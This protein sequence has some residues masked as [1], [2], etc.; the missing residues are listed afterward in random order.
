MSERRRLVVLQGL[1]PVD[2]AQVPAEVIAGITLAALA[3]PEVL[4]YS[5]IA[6]MPV[7]TGLYT[8]VLP[9]FVF[10][11]FGSS[12]H[13]VV[14]ADS[15]TAAVMAAALGGMAVAGSSRYVALAGL[16]ALMAGVYLLVARLIRLGF[17]AD[18]LSRTVL[19]GFLSGVG[20]Q[21]AIGQLAEALGIPKPT[22]STTRVLVETLRHVR[23][24]SGATVIVSMSV[25]IVALGSK[26]ISTR[27]PGA[28]VAV[29]GSIV[30]S[31]FAHLSQH[32]VAVLGRVPGGLPSFAV[33]H[34]VSWSDV[35]SLAPTA[36]SIL[37]LVLAQS[38]ATS[39]AYAAKY[40]DDFDENHDLTGLGIA[41]L[42]AAVTGTFV[43]NGSP[44]KTQMLDG[45]GGRSQL[46]HLT[47]ATATVSVLVLCTGPLQYLPKPALATIVLMIGL[48]L[49]DIAG[50]RRIARV[51][52]DEFVVAVVTA[53]TVVVVGVQQGIEL[54]IVV[55]IID[56]L[57]RSYRPITSVLVERDGALRPVAPSPG[58]RTRNALVVFRFNASLYY[59]NA[60]RFLEDLTAIVIDGTAGV[61]QLRWLCIDAGAIADVD[62]SAAETLRQL[63]AVAAAHGVGIAWLDL[64][65][66]VTAE[67]TT[68]GLDALFDRAM[69]FEHTAQVLDA[70]GQA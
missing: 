9:A 66:N 60:N 4:G 10:A 54:A 70:C 24:A 31:Y 25:V 36:L 39:R 69:R 37:V 26:L 38:A 30:V 51:R 14:G 35:R 19:V 18:F 16:L 64:Q 68:F 11:I 13:L 62:Y 46:A 3:I 28:L 57:R 44:T 52:R 61:P 41:N 40:A 59:A 56:H 49:V 2:R 7:V 55:A 20:I 27:V 21:V 1:R 8:L 29:V 32:G 65:P 63:H 48:D 22:G 43:V 53:V 47:M 17:I 58:L 33:P 42:A 6:G 50:L 5:S 12:R 34:D 45:A 15:A 67:F 23:S